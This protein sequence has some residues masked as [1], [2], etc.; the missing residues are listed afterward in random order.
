[1]KITVNGQLKEIPEKHRLQDIVEFFCPDTKTIVAEVN[2]QIIQGPQWIKID[3]HEGD[4]I[5]LMTF[6]GGGRS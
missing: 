2:G 4:I 5:E 6:M 3:I 1:M